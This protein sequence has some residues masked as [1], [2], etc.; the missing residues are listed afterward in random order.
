MYSPHSHAQSLLYTEIYNI[1]SFSKLYSHSHLQKFSLVTKIYSSEGEPCCASC[2]TPVFSETWSPTKLSR[3]SFPS[4]LPPS[5]NSRTTGTSN[6]ISLSPS[7]S[8]DSGVSET[9]S[10]DNS[11]P[12]NEV[13]VSD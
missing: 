13:H 6:V 8:T 11:D 3:S 12:I 2:I 9:A 10:N 1:S 5:V 4:V 7:P